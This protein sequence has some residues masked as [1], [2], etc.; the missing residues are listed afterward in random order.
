M[1]KTHYDL[2]RMDLENNPHLK[3]KVL[4]VTPREEFDPK[5]AEHCNAVINF[6]ETGKWS[7]R[8][9]VQGAVNVPYA[10]LQKMAYYAANNIKP[11]RQI[12]KS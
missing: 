4:R 10:C 9:D 8:L 7:K 3:P 12:T 1:R 5:N 6:L 11:K 2:N